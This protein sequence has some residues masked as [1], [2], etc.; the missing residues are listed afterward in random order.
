MALKSLL[1]QNF[2]QPHPQV[3][4]LEV[5][6]SLHQLQIQ[7][8]KGRMNCLPTSTILY[9]SINC[10]TQ[11]KDSS[12]YKRTYNVFYLMITLHAKWH[13]ALIQNLISGDPRRHH[14]FVSSCTQIAISFIT[15]T[16]HTTLFY[17]TLRTEVTVILPR[18]DV[19]PEELHYTTLREGISRTLTYKFL[20]EE[21][22]RSLRAS[23][24]I[25]S[26]NPSKFC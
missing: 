21:E 10:I 6:Q 4:V 5:L 11:P 17:V 25:G 22:T 15:Y 12:K 3:P 19:I 9:N 2:K 8:C 1:Y 23:L 7:V 13:H 14:L 16:I 24:I 18:K 20:I 26:L